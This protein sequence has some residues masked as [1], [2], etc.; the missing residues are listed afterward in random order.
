MNKIDLT[1]LNRLV[2]EL[3]D[4]VRSCEE[5]PT[6]T[7][8]NSDCEYV[9]VLSKTLGVATGISYEASGVVG[10]ILKVIKN[11]PATTSSPEDLLNSMFGGAL[12]MPKN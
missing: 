4:M 10:D 7:D 9:T 6:P 11:G 8:L 1:L 2:K 3:N 5:M 12:K